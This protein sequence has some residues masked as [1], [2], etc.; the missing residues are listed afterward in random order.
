MEKTRKKKAS[1]P[2]LF[3]CL[4]FL[5]SA[6]PTISEAGTGY[7]KLHNIVKRVVFDSCSLICV[8]K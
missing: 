4:R 5:N 2:V 6:D 3:S 1:D 8:C 7:F